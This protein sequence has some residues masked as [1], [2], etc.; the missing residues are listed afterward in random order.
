M[1]EEVQI[2]IYGQIFRVASGATTPSYVQQL[3][4]YVDDRMRSIA[5]TS[6][7]MPINRM[8][9]LTALNIADD[10]FKLRDTYGHS[11]H[12]F[13]TK[14]DHLIALVQEQFTNETAQSE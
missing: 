5:A 9:I 7:T 6:K 2:E 13:N 8:A 11:S 12:L 1:A 14:V 10:L 4:S 3:A